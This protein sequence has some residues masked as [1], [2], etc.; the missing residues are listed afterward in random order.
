VLPLA[1]GVTDPFTSDAEF[2][3]DTNQVGPRLDDLRTGDGCI[4]TSKA[5]GSPSSQESAVSKFGD[6]LERQDFEA[7]DEQR[8]VAEGEAG[9]RRAL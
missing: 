6:G 5:G 2:C 9:R 8:L 4:Q 3:V 7:A 1:E